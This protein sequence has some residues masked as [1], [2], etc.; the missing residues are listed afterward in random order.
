[1]RK[2]AIMGDKRDVELQSEVD[3]IHEEV[4]L[5]GGK[6]K[7][8]TCTFPTAY[9]ILFGLVCCALSAAVSVNTHSLP[10]HVLAVDNAVHAHVMLWLRMLAGPWGSS[11]LV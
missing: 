7:K 10:L 6:K 8:F 3:L 2:P 11:S 9:T 4:D 5:P 1:M